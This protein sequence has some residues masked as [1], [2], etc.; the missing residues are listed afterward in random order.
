MF[1]HPSFL[2]QGLANIESSGHS[3][4]PARRHRIAYAGNCN[5]DL[6]SGQH[7]SPPL[8][9][10]RTAVDAVTEWFTSQTLAIRTWS[11]KERLKDTS[12]EIV[13]VDSYKA[14]LTF[15]EFQE[16]FHNTEFAIVLPG[17]TAPFTHFLHETATCGSIPILQQSA[18]TDM[19][20]THMQN[21]LIY[22][23]LAS[24][25]SAIQTALVAP[26]DLVS[27]LRANL[28]HHI[29]TAYSPM[30]FAEKVANP[31]VGAVVLRIS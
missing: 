26:A 15:D 27:T 8:V 20:W 25:K 5:P 29:E 31:P 30:K 23:D 1:A 9:P 4:Q 17:I 24:L 14:G 12:A 13:L 19:G 2:L 18:V 16:L 6:Y 7:S 3:E 22:S 28:M 11:D 10:R 21:C